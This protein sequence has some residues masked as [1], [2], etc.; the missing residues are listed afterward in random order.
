MGTMRRFTITMLLAIAIMAASTVPASGFGIFE[1]IKQAVIKAIKAAD[2]AIQRQQ[3][4]IIWMQN[5]QKS[6]E[7]A[8]SKLRLREI[9]E[10]TEKQ[11]SQYQLYYE[12]L[13]KVKAAIATYQRMRD[14]VQRQVA[15]VQEFERT[16]AILKNDR[17]FTAEELEY[18]AR[19]Y[20]GILAQ[21]VQNIE[22][23]AMLVGSMR[24]QMG[25]AQRLELINRA[26]DRIEA[27]YADLRQ[28]N[29]QNSILS[30]S[31]SSDDNDR[32]HIK[33]LYG[34]R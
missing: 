16:W 12:E 4:K 3:N 13:R 19:V 32:V 23:M 1:I 29:R 27:N 30:L 20:A 33:R 22:Q 7:N 18:M 14:L 5:A 34:I 8:M 26:A 6:V 15:L 10:W 24:T 28:F 31:R 21:T 11:R 2:L 9:G 17:H 25:D